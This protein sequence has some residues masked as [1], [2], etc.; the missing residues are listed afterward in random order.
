MK[1]KYCGYE[2]TP[3]VKNPRACPVCKR[4]FREKVV[5]KQRARSGSFS[6]VDSATYRCDS[7]GEDVNIKNVGNHR[8]KNESSSS[9]GKVSEVREL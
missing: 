5:S 7:C 4:Y 3:R 6:R 2:W 9:D 1:C 8:C